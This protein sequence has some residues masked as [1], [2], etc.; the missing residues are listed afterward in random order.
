MDKKVLVAGCGISGIGAASMLLEAGEAVI[1]YDGNDTLDRESILG[2]FSCGK[3]P[4]LFLGELTDSLAAEISECVISPGIPTDVPFAKKLKDLGIPVIS[5]IEAAWK[6]ERGTVVGITGTNGKTTTTSLT[7]A[8]LRAAFGGEKTFVVGNIGTA[9]TGKA[10]LTAPDT[11][12]VAEISSFQLETAVRF[13]P[14]VSAILNITP[15]HLNRHKT[16][17]NYIAAKESITANQTEDDFCVLNYDDP[18]LRTFG[19]KSC[20]AK[21][22]WF[23][24]GSELE[25]GFFLRGSE[26]I[27]RRDGKEFCLGQTGE[28]HLVG[29]CNYEN[30]LAAAAIASCLGIGY[31]LIADTA[32]EFRA[33]EH[34]IEYT[35]T[36]R[37]V[38]YYNDSKGTNPDA[39]I[40]GI[41]AMTVPTCLI[42]GGYDKGSEYDSWIEEFG[43]T[44]KYLVLIGATAG[45]IADCCERHGFTA[46]EFADSLEEAVDKC[47]AKALPGE[48]VLLSPACASWGMFQNYEE[49]GR[50]F[51]ELVHRL[52]D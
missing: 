46:Y 18:V 27:A 3:K 34:R 15:D 38:K 25:E 24:G 33:V 51:K 2:K 40:Q 35:A 21:V 23:S 44:V 9:Y 20:P 5:E 12:T 11:F 19:E 37:G 42:G 13:R 52:P 49:R 17:E 50:L 7:G 1:L 4:E 41:R 22:V 43:S 47:A 14:H 48:A 26:L 16:M 45:A 29:R 28:F 30:I 36:K 6:Y 32:K 39:A 8:I 31:E 10:L